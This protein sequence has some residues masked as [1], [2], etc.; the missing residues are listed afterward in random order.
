MPPLPWKKQGEG[1][2]FPRP[3]LD[4]VTS[5]LS[6][7]TNVLGAF[8]EQGAVK[9]DEPDGADGIFWALTASEPATTI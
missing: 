2:Y 1:N 5:E 4:E 9:G 6:H 3:Y 7:W 8:N